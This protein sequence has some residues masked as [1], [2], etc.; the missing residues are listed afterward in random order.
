MF[1]FLWKICSVDSLPH[2]QNQIKNIWSNNK[3]LLITLSSIFLKIKGRILHVLL[4]SG[5]CF[6]CQISIKKIPVKHVSF[7]TACGMT[8]LFLYLAPLPIHCK[9]TSRCMQFIFG[10]KGEATCLIRECPICDWKRGE[11]RK[12]YEHRPSDKIWTR[13]AYFVLPIYKQKVQHIQPFTFVPLYL[14]VIQIC[15]YPSVSQ[16]IFQSS[17]NIYYK[18]H[19]FMM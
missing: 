13:K 1:G 11:G 7:Y 3:S 12:E 4:W 9:V 19:L 16:I 2:T 8:L 14:S 17:L 6:L 10:D 15:I 5:R 18:L